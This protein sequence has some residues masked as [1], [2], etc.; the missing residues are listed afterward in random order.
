MFYDPKFEVTPLKSALYWA[1]G[2]NLFAL[3]IGLGIFG[4]TQKIGCAFSKP[5]Y[6]I[7]GYFLI[8]F[9]VCSLGFGMAASTSTGPSNLQ[10]LHSSHLIHKRK[11][12]ISKISFFSQWQYD[13]KFEPLAINSVLIRFKFLSVLGDVAISYLAGTVLCL[14]VEMPVSALQKMLG[15]GARKH[16]RSSMG[17]KSSE[18]SLETLDLE[19]GPNDSWKVVENDIL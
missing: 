3:G 5:F 7:F 17:K 12:W 4:F 9:R 2:K 13:C 18:K 16:N 6:S 15:V 1:C 11:S 19:N 10:Y 14:L 8:F